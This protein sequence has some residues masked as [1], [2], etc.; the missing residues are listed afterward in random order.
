MVDR[1]YT[2]QFF[3]ELRTVIALDTMRIIFGK[4]ASNRQNT[5]SLAMQVLYKIKASS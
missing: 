3:T 1:E 5:T 2:I 4:T